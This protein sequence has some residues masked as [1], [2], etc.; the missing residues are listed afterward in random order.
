M[1][2]FYRCTSTV[3]IT[4]RDFQCCLIWFEI[5]LSYPLYLLFL[6]LIVHRCPHTVLPTDSTITRSSICC[7]LNITT[8]IFDKRAESVMHRIV[9]RNLF[10]GILHIVSRANMVLT[11]KNCCF[12]LSLKKGTLIIGLLEI[13]SAVFSLCWL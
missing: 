13:V 5:F 6:T 2:M 10:T 11:P 8:W 12:F 7:H 3:L 1:Y 4:A 9:T